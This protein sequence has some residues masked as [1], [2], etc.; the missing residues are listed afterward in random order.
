[1]ISPC[2]LVTFNWVWIGLLDE[3]SGEV[4]PAAANGLDV[5]DWPLPIINIHAGILAG[6]LV[7]Q[8][9]RTSSVI[10]SENGQS[11]ERIQVLQ[12]RFREFGFR[13]TA[14]VP[15]R[16]EGRVIG[17]LTLLSQ[18]SGLFNDIQEIHLLEEMG[19]DISFALNSME[20]EAKRRQ[21]E[22]KIEQAEPASEGSPRDR[23]S[24]SLPPIRWKALSVLHQ[25]IPRVARLSASDLT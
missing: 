19:L 1:M 2:N 21:G 16:L 24:Y 6:G 3:A 17:V 18:E 15:F 13:S 20:T 9:I 7:A 10:T 22:E 12:D 11:D 14:V 23:H 4:R 8:A 25:V 5:K